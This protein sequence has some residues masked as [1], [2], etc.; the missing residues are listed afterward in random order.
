MQTDG[1]DQS[2]REVDEISLPEL[3]TFFDLRRLLA[4]LVRVDVPG[5][6]IEVGDAGRRRSTAGDSAFPVVVRARDLDPL[7]LVVRPVRP[8]RV[9]CEVEDLRAAPGSAPLVEVERELLVGE[10][11]LD[12]HVDVVRLSARDVLGVDD[13]Q[14]RARRGGVLPVPVERGIALADDP[15]ADIGL[16]PTAVE[17]RT[18]GHASRR[19]NDHVV[20]VAAALDDEQLP[21]VARP[22][23][24]VER[25]ERDRLPPVGDRTM[26]RV[27]AV[28]VALRVVVRTVVLPVGGLVGRRRPRQQLTE[29]SEGRRCDLRDGLYPERGG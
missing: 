9:G 4:H 11:I 26:V 3:E 10:Q 27:P 8:V 13:R 21:V 29:D 24:H 19:V 6:G 2:G 18:V 5:G 23:C 7:D 12:A 14:C 28:R 15:V 22:G 17:R 16:L 20:P 25:V 1:R